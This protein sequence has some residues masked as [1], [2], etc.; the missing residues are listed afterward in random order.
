MTVLLF[1]T[2]SFFFLSGCQV[3][4]YYTTGR[5]TPMIFWY[6]SKA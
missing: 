1:P 3:V 2:F 6:S 5:E 4:R